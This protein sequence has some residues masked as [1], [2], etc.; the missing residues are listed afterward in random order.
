M[1]VSSPA[2]EGH[3]QL[4]AAAPPPLSHTGRRSHDT[5]I[6]QFPKDQVYRVPPRENAVIVEKHR[7]P[8]AANKK[9]GSCCFCSRR[10]LI[11]VALIVV[12]VVAIVG[13]TLATLYFILN[14]RGP[15]FKV[16]HVALKENN[17]STRLRYEVLLTA[18]NH[19]E[20]LAVDYEYGDVSLFFGGDQV[21]TGKFPVLGQHREESS[22][23][24][25]QLFGSI[26]AWPNH[27]R[28]VDLE[29]EMQL[30][31]RVVAAGLET[32]V[33]RSNVE[34]WFKISAPRNETRLL[35][36][37]CHTKFNLY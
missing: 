7:N 16:S 8:T 6:V 2:M 18:K 22:K 20:W 37:Y 36:Q 11:T 27:A 15:T 9:R 25:V 4:T 23:V 5:Y 35:S 32:W 13:I 10:L 1:T 21:A 17:A 24:K 28:A 29:L 34:C 31:L 3:A 33:M 14:P 19:N 30:G 26:W 12:A